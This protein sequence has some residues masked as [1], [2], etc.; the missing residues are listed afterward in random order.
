MEDGKIELCSPIAHQGLQ[1]TLSTQFCPSQASRCSRSRCLTLE[2]PE[3]ILPLHSDIGL[4]L[5]VQLALV[6]NLLN[7]T[8]KRQGGLALRVAGRAG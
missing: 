6:H 8:C 2:E 3:L 4:L 7:G 1:V 5:L